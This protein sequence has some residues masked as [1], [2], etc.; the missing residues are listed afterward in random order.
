MIVDDIDLSAPPNLDAALDE[1]A[2]VYENAGTTPTS[3]KRDIAH[4]S[5]RQT[6]NPN[7]I[8]DVYS[9]SSH[10]DFQQWILICGIACS[11]RCAFMV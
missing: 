6:P 7:G 4:F 10:F 3:S 2:A 9:G 11:P 1:I 8:V 5:R